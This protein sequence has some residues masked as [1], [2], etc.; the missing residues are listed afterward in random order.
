MFDPMNSLMTID[1]AVVYLGV[2]RHVLTS[3][4]ARERAG[5][6][7][8]TLGHRVVR[9]RRADLDAWLAH[10]RSNPDDRT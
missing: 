1:Q 6:P 10:H 3:P 9:F 7:A 4:R 8:L 5:I 2:K